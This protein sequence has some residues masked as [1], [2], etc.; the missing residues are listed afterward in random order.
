MFK[1]LKSVSAFNDLERQC[2]KHDN[3]T[4]LNLGGADTLQKT[5]LK[6]GGVSVPLAF[7]QKAVDARPLT[8]PTLYAWQMSMI[9]KAKR[10][11]VIYLPICGL[12]CFFSGDDTVIDETF[13][14]KA[15]NFPIQTWAGLLMREF[16][17]RIQKRLCSLR[18]RR[19]DVRQFINVYDATALYQRPGINVLPIIQEEFTKLSVGDGLWARLQDHYGI[20][21]PIKFDSKLQVR[22]VP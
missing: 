18:L 22:N 4:Q 17:I 11:H 21:V 9:E 8:R 3:F 19:Y 2:G 20:E 16:Q 14:S 12:S 6:K 1:A 7:C 13:R 5:I 15:V 10:E